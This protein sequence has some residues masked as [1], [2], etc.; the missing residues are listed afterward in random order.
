[1]KTIAML[2][3]DFGTYPVPKSVGIVILAVRKRRDGQPDMRT[4]AGRFLERYRD[5]ANEVA[6]EAY[7]AGVEPVM[8]E[9]SAAQ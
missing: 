7:A 6:A 8:P 3:T 5:V 4:A 2:D 1:M 9:A